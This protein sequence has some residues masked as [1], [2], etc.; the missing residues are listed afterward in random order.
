[1]MFV[2]ISVTA[3]LSLLARKRIQAVLILDD[4]VLTGSGYYNTG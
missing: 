1:M 3:D 2:C 4:R